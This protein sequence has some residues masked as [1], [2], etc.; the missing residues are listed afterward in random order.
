[1]SRPILDRFRLCLQFSAY[2]IFALVG[3]PTIFGNL[4]PSEEIVEAVVESV[5]SMKYN[6]YAPSTGEL[7]QCLGGFDWPP[8]FVKVRL[9]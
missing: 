3:D 8:N 6:G 9:G 1:M 2:F 4:C 5:R 7:L